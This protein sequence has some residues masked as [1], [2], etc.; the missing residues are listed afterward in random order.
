MVIVFDVK[1]WKSRLCLC[2]KAATWRSANN[3]LCWAN[4]LFWP[5][6]SH[7]IS[8]RAWWNLWFPVNSVR[9][10]QE[11]GELLIQNR[12][13]ILLKKR[14][15]GSV[16]YW[17]ENVKNALE[18]KNNRSFEANITH[19]LQCFTSTHLFYFLCSFQS[20]TSLSFNLLPHW[21]QQNP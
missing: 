4:T 17:Q 20:N 18:Y 7:D 9:L 15:V 2:K 3:Q 13:V 11:N 1:K 14:N 10:P 19:V 21:H 16:K 8:I 6:I 12:G 5:D